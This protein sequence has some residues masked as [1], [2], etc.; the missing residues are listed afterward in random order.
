MPP[1]ET[2]LTTAEMEAI[3][4]FLKSSWPEDIQA[5][6]WEISRRRRP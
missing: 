4:I 5:A 1:Y 2:I 3:L 6:Q